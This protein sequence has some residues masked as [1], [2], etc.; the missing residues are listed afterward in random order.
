MGSERNQNCS[1]FKLSRFPHTK[2]KKCKQKLAD[3]RF[4]TW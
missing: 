4:D 2:P 1:G 3:S